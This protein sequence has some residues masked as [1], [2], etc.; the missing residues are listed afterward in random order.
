MRLP[1]RRTGGLSNSSLALAI[2]GLAL[3]VAATAQAQSDGALDEITVVAR[4]RAENLQEVPI[5]VTVLSGEELERDNLLNFTSFETRFPAFSVYLTNPKQLNLGIRGIGNNGF[6]TDGID[7]SVGVFVDGVYTGRL[8]MGS[9]DYADID[10]VELLRGPQG[11]LFGKNTTAGAVIINSRAPSFAPEIAGEAGVGDY[12]YDEAKINVSGPVIGDRLAARLSAFTSDRGG[13]YPNAAGGSVNGRQGEGV[14]LQL[15]ERVGDDVTLRLI[16]SHSNQGFNSPSPVTMGIYNPAALQARM[17]AAGYPLLVSDDK[18]REVNLNSLIYASTRANMI[19]GQINWDLGDYGSLTSIT[20]Y[21]TWFCHTYN[22][23]DYTQLD[24][25]RD[26]GSCNNERQ[27]SQETRWASPSGRAVEAVAGSFV[28]AQEL[29]VSSRITFGNQYNIWAANPSATLFPNSKAGTWASGYY[30]NLVTGAGMQSQAKFHTDTEASFA[31][32]T[33]HPDEAR[34]WSID[35]GLR[36]TWE[37]KRMTYDGWV[38]ANPGGLSQAQLNLLSP[39]SGNAQ[40]GQAASS[41][42]DYSLS[43]QVGS[44]YQIDQDLMAYVEL[45]R[46]HKSKGFNLL[47]ENS[48]NPDPNVAQAILHGATQ[49]IAGEESDNVEIGVK[50]QWFDR[51]LQLNGTLF[52]TLVKNYQ[53]NESIGSGTTATKFLANVGFMRSKGAEVEAAARVA[54]GLSLQGFVAYDMAAYASFRNAACPAEVTALS[55]DLTGRQ[56]AWAPKWTTDLIVD[57]R[58]P[59]NDQVTGYVELDEN[60]R[61]DQNTTIT[62]DPTAQIRGYALTNLRLG[63]VFLDGRVDA[64][65]WFQNLFNQTYWVNLLGYTKST[66]IIQGYP[67]DP[68]MVGFTLRARM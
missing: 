38:T 45:A 23:N 50:S 58:R 25:I 24:A 39:A 13:D 3:G 40:L 21:Q 28:S 65:L 67:G 5:P 35:A 17:S 63:A 61:S 68:F 36:P 16:A 29:L 46:G 66:G 8:G 52:D 48:S 2:Y 12:G 19:N 27:F 14:R 60:W 10:Q 26:Y 54:E 43:G 64:Q 7:G 20:A 59:L 47:A 22:D 11:T 6:N 56:V 4:K 55:C 34:R 53:A 41:V 42:D 31:N 44:H 32:V 57:Y 30:A 33:W 62:L 18:Q 9:G 1:A 51:R 15:L 49:S 37:S